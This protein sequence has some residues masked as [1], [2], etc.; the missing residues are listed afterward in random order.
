MTVAALLG[1]VVADP[2]RPRITWYAGV[3]R[4]ELSG[5]VLDNWVTKTTH[6][7]VDELDAEPGTRVLLDL[8]FHWRAAVWALA[9]L[10]TGATAVLPG[11]ADGAPEARGAVTDA[12][13]TDVGSTDVVVTDVAERHPDAADLVV[14]A[15]PALAR[16]AGPG[17]PPGAIDAAA[18]V[19][20]YP[21]QPGWLP[22]VVPDAP[23]LRWPGGEVTHARLAAWA[24]ERVGPGLVPPRARVL[25]TGTDAVALLA[26]VLRVLGDDGSLVLVGAADADELRADPERRA[27]LVAGERVTLDLLG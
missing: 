13:A 2:G 25:A 16:T 27:R 7:L 24:A 1:L 18:A 22:P 26:L 10:R 4:V 23:A 5:H 14:V 17:L 15:L 12:A 19:M 21:D 3:E 8:P 11:P 6:M 9:T 20:T